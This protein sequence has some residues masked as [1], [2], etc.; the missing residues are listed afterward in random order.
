MAVITGTEGPETLDGTIDPDTIT[1]LGGNDTLNGLDGDDTLNG[2]AGVDTVNGG[3]GNDT[4]VMAEPP[5]VYFNGVSLTYEAIDGGADFD[6]LELRPFDNPALIFTFN[7]GPF[8]GYGLFNMPIAGVEHIHLASTGVSGVG[9]L[10]NLSQMT[11]SG[12]TQVTGGTLRDSLI[13]F[14]STAGTYTVPSLTLASWTNSSTPHLTGDLIGLAVNGPG[15]YTLNA[16]EGLASAQ[17]LGGGSGNDTL[18]GSSGSEMLNGGG[19]AN[20]LYGNGGDDV[21]AVINAHDFPNG[22]LTTYTGAGSTFDG[23]TGT[24]LLL[25]GGPVNFQGTLTSI[26]GIYLQPGFDHP[27]A[28]NAFD[29]DPAFLTITDA[30]LDTLPSNVELSGTGGMDVIMSPGDLFDGSGFVH[31]VGSSVQ[32]NVVGSTANDKIVGTS[33]VNVL[34]GN[35]GN[36]LLIAGTGIDSL[37]G[38]AGNDVLY[39]GADLTSG[40]SAFGG[41]GRDAIVLQGNYSYTFSTLNLFEIESISVQ[42]GSKTN[43]GDTANNFYD[44]DLTTLDMHV[45]AGLQMIVNGQSLRA[46]EDFTFDGSAETDGTFLVFAGHGVDDL[47]GGAG[48]DIFHFEGSRFGAGDSIDGGGGRDAAVI[49]AGNGLTHIEFAEDALTSIESVS[50][51]NRFASDPS[52]V[53]SYEL[54]L[55]DGNTAA[56]AALIV[57][58]A[59]LSATQTFSVDGSAETDGRLRLF[60][61][62]GTDVLIGGAGNDEI[63]GGGSA[64]TLTGGLGQDSFRYDD[65]SQSNAIG[66]DG[67]QDFTNGDKIDLSRIDAD[68]GTAGD[69]A[70]S[71]IGNSAFSNTAGELRFESVAGPIWLVQGDIDGNGVSDFEVIVV[72]TDAD[73]ITSTDFVL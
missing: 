57:N 43:W 47:T 48:N 39:F 60:G 46:G 2:G 7:M 61:G 67:I 63:Y 36:D 15:D 41:D 33:G 22:N 9:A 51:N 70:F 26:E 6:T 37:S 18:N 16:L 3:A 58:G 72:V 28:N 65:A 30:L 10:I 13:M 8:S 59:S 45:A 24:D 62:A 55:A 17:S 64:D 52:A 71:F 53:P 12:I 5:A 68:S 32:V 1:G 11:A 23:G 38:G 19:G 34:V 50:V 31:A 40:D 42:S 49:S 73:P 56:N 21:L 69:Q 25:I 44:Y 29:Q 20:L 4:S 27:A 66:R 35:D 54:V 14:A